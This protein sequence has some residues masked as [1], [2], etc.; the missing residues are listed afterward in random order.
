MTNSVS[1]PGLHFRGKPSA[2]KAI[3]YSL[4]S[5]GQELEQAI[6]SHHSSYWSVWPSGF[7]AS[8]PNP[9]SWIFT[10]VCVGSS[11]FYYLFTPALLPLGSQYL[12][13]LHQMIVWKTNRDCDIT[14]PLSLETIEVQIKGDQWNKRFRTVQVNCTKEWHST[15]PIGDDLP[16]RSV[17]RNFPPLQ[18]PRRNHR[19]FVWTK[20]LSDMVFVS[21]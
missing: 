14:T 21:T 8:Y 19:C 13:T 20:V 5:N 15:Y 9:Q 12:F 3:R 2:W 17:R 18:K 6:H 16:S 1:G 11:L 7:S 10:I 4:N